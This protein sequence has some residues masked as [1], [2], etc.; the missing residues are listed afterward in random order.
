MLLEI[1]A[2]I[3][4][5]AFFFGQA[6]GYN[7]YVGGPYLK[8]M[9]LALSGLLWFSS[10]FFLLHT[11]LVSAIIAGL[12][13]MV[14]LAVARGPLFGTYQEVIKPV[15]K[16]DPLLKLVLKLFGGKP[17]EPIGFVRAT[18]YQF[19]HWVL[20]MFGVGYLVSRPIAGLACGLGIL[21]AYRIVSRYFVQLSPETFKSSDPSDGSNYFG[22][23]FAGWFALAAF[24]FV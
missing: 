8:A 2:V 17:G 14:L 5:G 9:W 16:Q 10:F 13:W 1:L 19:S 3:L 4:S 23:L 7:Q 15:E 20:P 6:A 11:S 24:M 22:A 18:V 12:V 21:F